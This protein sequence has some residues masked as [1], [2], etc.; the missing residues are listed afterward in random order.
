[1]RLRPW[2]WQYGLWLLLGVG[3]RV[4]VMPTAAYGDLH[5]IA[6]ALHLLPYNGVWDVYAALHN[7]PEAE[8]PVAWMGTDF[9]PYPPLT[10]YLLGGAMLLLRPLYGDAFSA[11]V[12]SPFPQ[13]VAQPG[14]FLWLTLYKLPFLVADLAMAFLLTAC[15][16]AP[17]QKRLAFRLWMLNP[18]PII[19]AYLFGQFDLLPAVLV[20]AAYLAVLR[21]WPVAGAVALGLG[22]GFKSYPLLLLP[23]Y[24]LVVGRSWQQRG[25]Y[26]LAGLAAFA[27]TLLPVLGSP[28][29]L[30]VIFGS[31]PSRRV[32]QAGIPLGENL[33]NV[34][35]AYLVLLFLTVLAL[36]AWRTALGRPELVGRYF[37]AVLLLTYGFAF[38]H[39][40]WFTWSVPFLV[41]DWVRQPANRP[42]H[43]V[44]YLAAL[45]VGLSWQVGPFLEFF[46]PV[47][48]DLARALPSLSELVEPIMPIGD[49]A[50]IWRSAFAGAA[51]YWTY[52]NVLQEPQEKPDTLWGGQPDPK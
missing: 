42:A 33:G 5:A 7:L 36:H 47:S 48:P 27:L 40:Q 16:S 29:A 10:Y 28:V 2:W 32:L 34:G 38:S 45:L 37:L 4:L 15:F 8:N 46:L 11:A 44:L 24:A 18:V 26:G 9:F 17:A 25:G 23:L 31:D 50:N 19:A 39:L 22:A 35:T 14:I 12:S 21:G 30:K 3:L 1:M 6:Y 43:A 41:L 51:L 52:T 20:L 49:A 13:F